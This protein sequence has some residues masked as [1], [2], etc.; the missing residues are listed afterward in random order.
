[1]REYPNGRGSS[2]FACLDEFPA[3]FDTAPIFR[4]IEKIKYKGLFSVEYVKKDGTYYFLE[5]NLR[6]DGNGYIPTSAGMN[7]PLMFCL[8][9]LGRS[10]E[11][12]ANL[13]LPQY[14][15]SDLRDINH[16]FDKDISLGT[17][18]IDY[19]RTNVFLRYNKKDPAPT[20]GKWAM[21]RQFAVSFAKSVLRR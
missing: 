12:E 17:W 11:Y 5:I 8:G 3:D 16:V 4:L 18:L 13:K 7:E 21:L 19:K 2:S 14:F 6:N 20:R 9:M 10:E 1:M 15:M